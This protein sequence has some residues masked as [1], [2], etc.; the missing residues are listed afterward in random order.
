MSYRSTRSGPNM[1]RAPRARDV[2]KS[3]ES[4]ADPDVQP[5]ERRRPFVI[6]LG[7]AHRL[8]REQR[9]ITIG[10][11][12]RL[13]GPRHQKNQPSHLHEIDISRAT[14]CKSTLTTDLNTQSAV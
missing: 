2:P 4:P 13:E 9:G 10:M 14:S 12:Q 7:G 11:S 8:W 3:R 6:V 1:S 5:Q